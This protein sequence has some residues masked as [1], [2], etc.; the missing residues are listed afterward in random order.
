M[1]LQYICHYVDTNTLEAGWILPVLGVEGEVIRYESSKVRSY[2]AEQKS[3]FEADVG[4]IGA[5][6]TALAG[7]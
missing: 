1:Q 3:E 2:S 7:W 4:E 5:S 6:Y